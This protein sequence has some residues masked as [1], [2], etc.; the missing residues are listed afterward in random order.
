MSRKMIRHAVLL[1]AAGVLAACA[2]TVDQQGQVAEPLTP[3][4]QWRAE[5]ST[6]PEEILLAAHA[7]GL[8]PRQA[9]ALAA[10]AAGWREVEGGTITIQ[11]P[12]GGAEPASAYRAA[13]A[14]RA[15]LV[16]QGVPGDLIRTVGYRPGDEGPAPLRIG[17][18]RHSVLLPECGREWTNIARSASNRVQPNF[19]CAVTANMAAQ[20]AN[21]AD[22]AGPRSFEPGD[23]QRRGVV[24]DKYRKGEPTATAVD[25]QANGAV[26]RVVN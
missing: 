18:L 5:L 19:G 7:S 10:F 17:Y 14:A 13:E 16:A 9:D 23:A 24:L 1:A 22:L 15:F 4:E 8:S 6:H 2:T 12:S 21:P 11:A 25:K 26:S 3:T 20:I